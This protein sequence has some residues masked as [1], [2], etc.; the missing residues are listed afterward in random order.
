[1]IPNDVL[2]YLQMLAQPLSS[3][4]LYPSNQWKQM[5]RRTT[6]NRNYVEKGRKDCKMRQSQE[7]NEKTTESTILGSQGI[8]ETEPATREFAQSLCTYIMVVQ[9]S[10]LVGLLAVE[11]GAVSDWVVP[12]RTFPLTGLP[13]P[14]L[15]EKQVPSLI[16]TS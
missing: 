11:G 1:M 2:L 8:T 13:C 15:T 14:T 16:S 7:Q 10:L 9:I 5:Q 6:K 4:R 3:E 12:L